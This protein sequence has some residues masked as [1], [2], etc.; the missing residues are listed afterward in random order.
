MNLVV[1]GGTKGIGLA[2]IEVFAGK[3]FDIITCARNRQ[4]LEQLKV[5]LE[6]RYPNIKVFTQVC[7]M[8]S[9]KEVQQFAHSILENFETIQVL[10]NNAGLFLPGS[11][12]EEADETFET[13]MN[14]NIGGTYHMTRG[15]LPLLKKSKTAHI[16]NLC[17]TASI[18]AHSNGGSYSISKFALLG[19]SK[20]LREELKPVAIKV[21]S[22]LPGPTLTNSWA[23][24]TLPATRFMEVNEVAEAVWSCYN[25]KTVVVEELVMRP[26]LGDI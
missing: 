21:T 2:I 19:F 22:V 12:G 16:F 7:D 3:G 9:K 11:I 1:T 14:I 25:L 10:V 5:S 24:T 15:L 4:E 18:T 17:S 6:A 8:G 13:V 20:V 23:G 26:Q